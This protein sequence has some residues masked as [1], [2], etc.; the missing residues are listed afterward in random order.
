MTA[1]VTDT[2]PPSGAVDLQ[3]APPASTG[4]PAEPSPADK[5][6]QTLADFS[7]YASQALRE[8]DARNEATNTP[9]APP[10]ASE[11]PAVGSD[12]VESDAPPPPTADGDDAEPSAEELAALSEA[13]RRALMAERQKRK[14]AREEARLL[15]EKVAELEARLKSQPPEEASP[16]DADK[17]ADPNIPAPAAV[18]PVVAQQPLADC[19]TFEAVDARVMQAATAE[20]QALKLQRILQRQGAEQ[21]AA[22]LAKLGVQ[23]IGDT[24]VAEATD[25]QLEEFLSTVYEHA[26]FSQAAAPARKQFLAQQAQSFERARS[27]VPELADPK[28][29]RARR[30]VAIVQRNPWLR[31][32]GPNWP[33]IVATQLL[34]EEVRAQRR[35]AQVAKAP[36]TPPLAPQPPPRPAPAAPRR[37]ATAE[38]RRTEA[39]EIGQKVLAGSATLEELG[40]LARLR[41]TQ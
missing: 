34:G 41:V 2:A 25:E 22:E 21:A 6:L 23:R 8:L 15:R 32:M 20:A 36:P 13:G 27:D 29:D 12:Q 30:F 11:S 38:P 24:P 14:E 28:S 17:P 39:D 3:P 5:P 31:T 26:R 33:E 19:Q 4:A 7:A 37:S 9:E 16:G 35:T 40:R 18:A 10:A 1:P